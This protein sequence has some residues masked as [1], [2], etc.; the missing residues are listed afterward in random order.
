L[1]RIPEAQQPALDTL[2]LAGKPASSPLH[3][4]AQHHPGVVRLLLS[5]GCDPLHSTDDDAPPPVFLACDCLPILEEFVE[6]GVPANAI[7][8][9]DDTPLC[10]WAAKYG[11]LD[12]LQLLAS[13]GADVNLSDVK[14]N[15]AALLAQR[16][17]LRPDIEHFVK[18]WVSSSDVAHLASYSLPST[19]QRTH[20]VPIASA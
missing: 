5:R 2:R 18:F 10:L 12:C 17:L 3:L 8:M 1:Q 20:Y 4:A 11:T 6:S 7:A 13:K 16:C 15:T 19:I 14:G 9:R